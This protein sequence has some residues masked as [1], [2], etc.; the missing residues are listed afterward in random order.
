MAVAFSMLILTTVASAFCTDSSYVFSDEITAREVVV[1]EED[2][3]DEEAVISV[4]YEELKPYVAEQETRAIL[5]INIERFARTYSSADSIASSIIVSMERDG[6]TYIGTLKL[7][8]ID[9]NGFTYTG[10]YSGTLYSE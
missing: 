4:P 5:W 1:L 7:V 8:D 2:L 6:Y 9:K 3:S 10:Y